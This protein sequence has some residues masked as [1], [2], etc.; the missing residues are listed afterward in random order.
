MLL[1][2]RDFAAAGGPVYGECGGL[3][4]LGRTLTTQA[5]ARVPLAG[6]L[7]VDTAMLPRLKV[8]GYAE[9]QWTQ[10]TLWG[11]AGGHCRGHEFH[12]SEITADDG[13]HSGWQRAYTVQRRR[14]P[15][16]AAGSVKGRVLAGYVHLHW[17]SRP[18]TV[19][20][21]LSSCEQSSCKLA[22]GRA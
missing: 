16:D 6:I 7:P 2:V 20:H 12:Y 5:G 18:E 11:P 22:S 10:D 8:L 13:L 14:G 21:F 9:V 1:D 15:A 3:M 17:A 19:G 4:Y